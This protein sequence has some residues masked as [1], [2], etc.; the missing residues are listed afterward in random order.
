MG[1][2][3]VSCR[4]SR[5]V[6]DLWKASIPERGIR[7][8]GSVENCTTCERLVFP[9]RAQILKNGQKILPLSMSVT[10]TMLVISL[11]N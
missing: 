5:E 11:P 3:S 1:F 7:L 4:F 10:V 8:A 6:H 2:V 9:G